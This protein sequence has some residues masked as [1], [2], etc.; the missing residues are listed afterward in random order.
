MSLFAV[1]YRYVDDTATL[2]EHRPR[3]RDHLRSLHEAGHLVI[4]GPLAE[5]GGPGALLIFRA[6]AAEQVEEWLEN[7]PFRVLELIVEREIRAWNP[8]FGAD[9]LAPLPAV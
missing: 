6:D 8:A 4:S 9:R 5:G 7:D 1:I 3:H 2:D